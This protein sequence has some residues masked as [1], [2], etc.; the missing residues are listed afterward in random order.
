MYVQ[1]E[2]GAYQSRTLVSAAQRSLNLYLE[3]APDSTGEPSPVAHNVTPGLVR[4]SVAPQQRIRGLYRSTQAKLYG[5]AGQDLYYISPDWAWNHIGHIQPSS[6]T[7]AVARTTPVSMIDNGADAILVD[8]TL[9]GYKW[10]PQTNDGFTRIT[11]D[12]FYGSIRADYIDTFYVLAKP[13]TPVWYCSGSMAA[14]FDSLDF[15]SKSAMA[16][17]CV[18][19]VPLHRSLFAIGV[20]STELWYN[21]GGGGSGSLTNNTFPFEI[22]PQFHEVGCA[23][24]YSIAKVSDSLLFLGQDVA[25]NC[26]VMMGS[27]YEIKRISTHAIET[28]LSKYSRIDDATG[29]TYQMQGHVVYQLNFTEA[30]KTWC[31]DLTTGQWFEKC[32]LDTNGIEHRHRANCAAFCYNTNTVGDWETGDLYKFDNTAFTDATPQGVGSGPIKRLR[33]FPHLIDTQ[34]NRRI[35]YKTLIA[36]MAVG[37]SQNAASTET[38]VETSFDATDGTLLE[39][40]VNTSDVNGKFVK[41][42]DDEGQVVNDAFVAVDSSA[43]VAYR[44][45]TAPISTSYAVSFVAATTVAGIAPTAGSSLWVMAR[46]MTVDNGYRAAI[47]SDGTN[48]SVKLTATPIHPLLAAVAIGAP[49]GSYR[50]TLDVN[51]DAITVA[52]QRDSDNTWLNP[53]GI[54]VPLKTPAISV[55][56]ESFPAPG[57]IFFG[58]DW[59]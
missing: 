36:N 14:T 57:Q 26:M 44:T 37:T 9:D 32:W 22:L 7:D 8:G 11:D 58:G 27:G 40:Y 59:T 19:V 24:P 49:S 53:Q 39:D 38:I 46:A 15:A 55:L 47:V 6:P 21:S 29:F 48:L 34:L 3:K 1:L 35:F 43:S 30:D 31:F 54:W 50:V 20:T 17:N 12:G 45:A 23:A 13:G 2:S 52:V 41:V 4:L 28:E 33:S 10:N 51:G 25:G 16:D 18:A 42:S 56:D 5:V